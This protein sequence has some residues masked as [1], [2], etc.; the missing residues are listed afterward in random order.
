MNEL[1][2]FWS[3]KLSSA[4][5]SAKQTGR[6]DLADYLQ[7]K[8]TNDAVRQTGVDEFFSTI[9]EIATRPEHAS[10]N[11][12]IERESPHDFRHRDAN[13]LGSVLRL[14]YGVRGM[15]AE[16]GWT[17]TPRDG[18]MRMGALA[19]ARITHFGIPSANAEFIL[20]STEAGAVWAVVRREK[21]DTEFELNDLDQ[22]FFVLI[23]ERP[24][25]P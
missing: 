3:E 21:V 20:K 12:S 4:I 5:E 11:V 9:I 7:L 14:R 22:H 16:A 24:N 13:M 10:R 19:F 1:D 15:T 2:Q 18:F 25:R 17:R 6:G 8:A 23:D